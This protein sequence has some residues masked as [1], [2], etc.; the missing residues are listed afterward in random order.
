MPSAIL[1]NNVELVYDRF[2]PAEG[3][4]VVLIPG[5][6]APAGFLPGRF[7]NELAGTHYCV[8]HYSHPDTGFSTH[9]DNPYGIDELLGDLEAFG[10]VRVRR[11]EDQVN[12][13]A[14]VTPMRGGTVARVDVVVFEAPDE[15]AAVPD[16][17]RCVTPLGSPAIYVEPDGAETAR[18]QFV[19][20]LAKL[21]RIQ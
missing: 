19:L 20:L 6:G 21:G 7:C 16:P 8:V 12:L 14:P 5:A 9:F 4:L 13:D 18:L 11:I 1:G 17:H 2:G 10:E 3:E 15:F